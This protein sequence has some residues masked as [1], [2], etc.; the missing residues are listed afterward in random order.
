MPDAAVLNAPSA[1]DAA[2]EAAALGGSRGGS[3]FNTGKNLESAFGNLEKFAKPPSTEATTIPPH[4]AQK[5]TEPPKAPEPPK[6][7]EVAKDEET[8]AKTEE[9]PAKEETA[10]TPEAQVKPKKPA[11]F[12]REELAKTKTE[13]DTLKAEM[14]KLKSATPTENPEIKTLTEQVENL[15]KEKERLEEEFK[16]VKYEK[17]P[18]YTEKFLKPY[19]DAWNR[20]RQMISRLKITDEAGNATAATPAQFDSLME[21]YLRDPEAAATKLEE[22]FGPRASLITPHM[23]EV[24]KAAIAADN[25]V[26]EYKKTSAEREKQFQETTSKVAKEINDHWTSATK[27][28]SV[29]DQWKPYVLPKGNDKDGNAI[30]KEGDALLEKGLAEFDR[31][32]TENARN[33]NLTKEQREGI[34]GRAA[35]IRN[36][37]ASFNRLVRDIRAKDTEI[38]ALKKELEDFK[39]SEPGAGDGERGT[40]KDAPQPETMEGALAALEK[41]GTPKFY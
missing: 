36:K 41:R 32:A 33:P 40:K 6:P 23:M 13:R 25:A 31:A 28:E 22:M 2:S 19:Q 30:D 39:A 11:D 24:E 8:P 18:D 4:P 16:Y 38:A 17:S 10:K 29:P 7:E 34:L 12:L 27:P 14:E 26:A 21:A 5:K 37:A 9:T 3:T 1:A 15:R 35:A 20:G